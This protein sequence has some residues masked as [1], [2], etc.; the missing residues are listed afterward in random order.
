MFRESLGIKARALQKSGGKQTLTRPEIY[1]II[2][3]SRSLCSSPVSNLNALFIN[4]NLSQHERIV[5]LNTIAINQM[6]L[7]TDDT[8]IRKIRG[9]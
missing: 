1:G 6:K 3:T 5:K 4:E 7:L 9:L 2:P 8:G